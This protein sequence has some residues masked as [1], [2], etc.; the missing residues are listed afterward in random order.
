MD[1]NTLT[2][3]PDTAE[4]MKQQRIPPIVGWEAAE[5][6]LEQWFVVVTVLMAPQEL[7]PAVF[8]L[9]TLLEAEEGVSSR[10]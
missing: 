6:M 4:L 2:S 10:L 7:L 5:K 3:Y 8:E 9:V 1:S